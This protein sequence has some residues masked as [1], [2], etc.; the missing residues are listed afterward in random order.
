MYISSATFLCSILAIVLLRQLFTWYS[1]RKIPG[2]LLAASTDLWRAYYFNNGRLASKLHALHEK[3]GPVVRTGPNHVSVSDPA[4]VP[5]IYG[6]NPV[7]VKGE[8]YGT[9]MGVR[10]GREVPTIISTI[11]EAKHTA[12]RRG[13]GN[14]FSTNALLD[15]EHHL[16]RSAAELVRAVTDLRSFDM[17]EWFQFYTMDLL[18]RV[19]FSESLGFVT[20]GHDVDGIIQTLEDRFAYYNRW[21]ALRWW[22]KLLLK[23]RVVTRFGAASSPLALAAAGKLAARRKAVSP[24]EQRDLLQKYI[25]ASEKYPDVIDGDAILGF[26]MSTIA[27]GADTTAVTITAVLY[28]LLKTPGSMEK[29]MSEIRIAVKEGA[30]SEPPT[31]A[32]ANRLRYLDVVIKEALRCYPVIAVPFDR[33][34]PAG[35]AEISGRYVPEGAVVACHPGIIHSNEDLYG[36][37]AAIFRPERW[38]EADEARRRKLERAFLGFGS[39]KRICIGQHIAMLEMKKLIPHLLLMFEVRVPHGVVVRT[40]HLMLTMILADEPR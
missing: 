8:S 10:N 12:I 1:L 4:G 29:L 31:Y 16:D 25:E 21:I 27:A 23:N 36:D 30:M 5:L 6:T 20:S 14:A 40:P 17:C 13:I 19:A 22:E 26:C 28:F 7:W 38:L 37:D 39:G 9:L 3:Y 35:G 24:P 33:V 18:S 2:P 32:E 15:Y 34:V 11:S